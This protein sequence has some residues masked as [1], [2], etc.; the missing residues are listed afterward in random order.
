VESTGEAVF[1]L[2]DS[3]GEIRVKLGAGTDGSGLVLL[4]GATETGVHMQVK[5]RETTLTLRNQDGQ[6][7]LITP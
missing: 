7:R 4:N 6:R 3:R 2:R 1:R 5:G